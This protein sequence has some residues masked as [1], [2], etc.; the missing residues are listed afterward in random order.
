MY[1]TAI[2]YACAHC[3]P[4]VK[5]LSLIFRE[6]KG[7]KVIKPKL[8]SERGHALLV[9]NSNMTTKYKGESS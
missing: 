3:G 5:L 1:G 9:I 7:S 6:K 8:Q 2:L 4:L